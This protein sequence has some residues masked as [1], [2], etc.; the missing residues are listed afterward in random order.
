MFWIVENIGHESLLPIFDPEL[1][2]KVLKVYMLFVLLFYHLPYA[3]YSYPCV[4]LINWFL[5][6]FLR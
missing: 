6:H 5:L 2:P 4:I 3:V 1:Q